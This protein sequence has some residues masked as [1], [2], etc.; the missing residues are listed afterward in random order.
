MASEAVPPADRILNLTS[1]PKDY[2]SNCVILLVIIRYWVT[3]LLKHRHATGTRIATER[4]IPWR[5]ALAV[6]S[7]PEDRRFLRL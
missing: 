7:A 2:E 3:G 6:A 4:T 1:W 5:T